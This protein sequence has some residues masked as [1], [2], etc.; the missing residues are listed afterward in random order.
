MISI[1]T[2]HYVSAILASIAV[3]TWGVSVMVSS[4]RQV[5]WLA[6]LTSMLL[7][8]VVFIGGVIEGPR[9]LQLSIPLTLILAVPAIGFFL[10]IALIIYGKVRT[11]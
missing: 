8:I 4:R 5:L 10:G 1:D 6:A 2:F 9:E 3:L 11:F 7:S